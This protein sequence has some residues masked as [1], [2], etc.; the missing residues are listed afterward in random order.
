MA[1]IDVGAV[2]GRIFF[3]QL[4][5]TEQAGAGKAAF[6]QVVAEDAVVGKTAGD[7]LLKRVDGIDTLADKRALLEYVL[8]NVRNTA[9]VRVDT[10]IAA[11]QPGI[12]RACGAGQADANARL[13]NA[14]AAG[15]AL[16]HGVEHRV[17]ER[18]GHGRNKLPGG[19]AGQ[20][21]VGV[22]GDD[23][24]H[25]GQA[26]QVTDDQGEALSAVASEQGV[27]LGDF[28]ALA[29]VAH[30]QLVLRVPAAWPV[31]QEEALAVGVRVFAV[32]RLDTLTGEQQQGG[33]ALQHFASRIHK[34]G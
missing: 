1:A 5:I 27:E 17:I 25:G 6:N 30:P 13:K 12:G 8:I 19:V 20:L 10:S 7:G 18:V 16:L 21:A 26:A 32:E 28:P 9:G 4:H 22:E 34:I 2:T 3:I 33:I 14:V 24:T 23:V 31:K 29:F 15:N 11:K